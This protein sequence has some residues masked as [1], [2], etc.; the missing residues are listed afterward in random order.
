MFP[1]NPTIATK[2]TATVC[3]RRGEG[4]SVMP[5]AELVDGNRYTFR[6]AWVIEEDDSTIYVGETAWA[7]HP[8]PISG[9]DNEWPIDAPLWIAS[10]DLRDV[11]TQHKEG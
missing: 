10:G 1:R 8:T 4:W 2:I 6:F 11:V 9:T 7:P 5:S 3:I